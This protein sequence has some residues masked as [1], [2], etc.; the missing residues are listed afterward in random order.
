MKHTTSKDRKTN[1]ILMAASLLLALTPLA[2]AGQI[3]WGL[4]DVTI[5]GITGSTVT[6]SFVWDTAL[7]SGA[8]GV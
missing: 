3:T 2:Q 5:G 6:G 1:R 7:N 4:Q 8:G